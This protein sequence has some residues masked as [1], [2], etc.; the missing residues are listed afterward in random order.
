MW[1]L[2]KT[3]QTAEG[4]LAR[5]AQGKPSHQSTPEERLYFDTRSQ[6]YDQGISR[7]EIDAQTIG[8]RAAAYPLGDWPGREAAD[9]LRG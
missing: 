3:L 4:I 2:K 5:K 1:D 6:M 9:R 8:L 7:E